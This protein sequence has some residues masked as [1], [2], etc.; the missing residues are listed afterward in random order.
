MP[1]CPCCGID[2]EKLELLA[3]WLD[4]NDR[5]YG[6]TNNDIQNDLRECSERIKNATNE[7][8]KKCSKCG[9]TMSGSTCW[10]CVGDGGSRS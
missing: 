4:F 9:S 7:N 8:V 6:N 5:N 1:K 2:S 3:S 10:Q